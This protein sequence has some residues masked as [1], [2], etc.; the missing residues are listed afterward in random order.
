VFLQHLAELLLRTTGEASENKARCM[1]RVSQRS[2]SDQLPLEPD[3]APVTPADLVKIEKNL[4]YISFFSPSKSRRSKKDPASDAR[5]RTIT[6]PSREINGKTVHPRLSSNPTATWFTHD[7]RPRQV[8]GL[9]EDRNGS[10]G[11]ARQG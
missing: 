8:H 3:Q 1:R 2:T 5:V 9:H 4:N 11:Q 6:Y 7:R 10:E